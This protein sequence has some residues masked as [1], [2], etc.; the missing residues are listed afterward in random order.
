MEWYPGGQ[1]RGGVGE[2]ANICVA[3]GGC[4]HAGYLGSLGRGFGM[5]TKVVDPLLEAHLPRV[6]TFQAKKGGRKSCSDLLNER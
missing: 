5:Q 3:D 1:H 4:A 6:K 2:R